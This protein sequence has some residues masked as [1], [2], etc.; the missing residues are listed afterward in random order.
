MEEREETIEEKQA[1]LKR[2]S[3]LIVNEKVHDFYRAEFLNDKA[4][5]N[6]AYK[7][8]GKKY[9]DEI[10]IGFAPQEGKSLSRLPL[11]RA[12]LEELGLIN[13]QGYDFFQ[14]R[15]VI[16]SVHDSSTS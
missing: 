5:Q 8:W 12:F 15:I 2:E 7:R 4:A 9:C 16:P 6:Y 3:L 10:S 13:K 1:R 11:Q 14:H